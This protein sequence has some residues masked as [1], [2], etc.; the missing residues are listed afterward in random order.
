MID[1]RILPLQ[2]AILQPVATLLAQR[3]VKADTISLV[4]CLA[5]FSAFVM[6]G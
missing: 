3:G 6:L 5:G 4:G 2:K 1:A